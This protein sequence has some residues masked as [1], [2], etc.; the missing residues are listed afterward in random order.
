MVAGFQFDKIFIIESL[1]EGEWRTGKDLYDKLK[2]KEAEI[3][4]LSILYNYVNTLKELKGVLDSIIDEV[5]T[6]GTYPIIHFEIHGNPDGLVLSSNELLMW[7]ELYEH[8]IAVNIPINNNLFVTLAVCMGA[9]LMKEIRPTRSCPL[10]GFVGSFDELYSSDMLMRYTDF[11]LAFLANFNLDDAV[12]MLVKPSQH[13]RAGNYRFINS[14]ELFKKAYNLYLTTQY[15][16]LALRQRF[17]K[18]FKEEGKGIANRKQKN[19]FYNRF[20]ASLARTKKEFF[21]KHRDTFFLIDIFP[22]NKDL[23]LTNYTPLG[24]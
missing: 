7:N 9:Y 5:E 19:E 6:I 10:W 14:E 8:L 4:G 21:E 17:E 24:E 23:Y 11:Y 12:K 20:R 16:P 1:Y 15:E 13:P 18:A 3:A 22:E 2:V